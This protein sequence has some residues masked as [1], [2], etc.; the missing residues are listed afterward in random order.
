MPKV[1]TTT[2]TLIKAVSRSSCG[3][4]QGSLEHYP[5]ALQV[6]MCFLLGHSL[7][8]SPSTLKFASQVFVCSGGPEWPPLQTP[9]RPPPIVHPDT[10]LVHD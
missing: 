6:P 10:V 4:S 1:T 7:P 2:C 5:N 3:T 8:T 9:L